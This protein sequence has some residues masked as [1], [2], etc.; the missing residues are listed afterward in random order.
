MNDNSVN[1]SNNQPITLNNEATPDASVFSVTAPSVTVIAT[2]AI[3]D[4]FIAPGTHFLSSG[5]KLD[6]ELFSK[7]N[8]KNM[9]DK[10]TINTTPASDAPDA[11]TFDAAAHDY[12]PTDSNSPYSFRN[13]KLAP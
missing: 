5:I 7:G 13:F 4:A 9:S 6:T 10:G 8:R 1:E 3:E 12:D 2:A 11:D